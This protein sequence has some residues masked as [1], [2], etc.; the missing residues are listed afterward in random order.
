MIKIKICGL[1]S[2]GDAVFCAGSGADYLGFVFAESPRRISPVKASGI[3]KEIRDMGASPVGVFVNESE[4]EIKRISDMCRLDYIQLHGDESPEFCRRF[5]DV[6]V[7]KALRA[8]DAHEVMRI[9]EYEADAYVLD[10]FT[11]GVYGGTG[12]TVAVDLARKALSLTDRL[13]LSGGLT[14]ENVKGILAEMEPF[15]VDVSSGVEQSP[16]VKDR[17]KLSSFI[18]AVRNGGGQKDAPG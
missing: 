17:E 4:Y 6:G 9:E 13:I 18:N 2:L 5:K 1:T 7:F 12:K 11:E 3:A 10:S 14:H 15:G 16:G 8:R